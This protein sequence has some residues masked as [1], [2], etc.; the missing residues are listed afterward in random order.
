MPRRLSAAAAPS[1]WPLT[2]FGLA[3]TLVL[4]AFGGVS[5]SSPQDDSGSEVSWAGL[6]GAPRP[7]VVVGQR[8][9]VVLRT[10]ALSDHVRAAGGRATDADQRRWVAQARAAQQLVLSRL[11]VQGLAIQPDHTFERVLNGFAA[12][13]DPRAVAILERSEEVKGI[14]PV[15]SAYPA[16]V[17]SKLLTERD[18]QPGSGHRLDVTLPGFDGRG[19][20]VAL[21]DTGVDRAQ[22]YLR[23]RI[24]DGVDIVGGSDLALAAPHPENPADLERHGTELAGIIVG[25]SGPAD[26]TGVATGAWVLPIRVAGWQRDAAGGY[27]IYARTDQLLAGLERAVDPNGDGVAHDAARI[28]VIGVAEPYNAFADGPLAQAV[29]GALRL[30]TLVVAPAGNDGIGAAQS[31]VR[32]FG[33]VAGPGGAPAALTVGALDIRRRARDVRVTIRAGLQLAYEGRVP[34]GGAVR[35]RT[36]LRLPLAAPLDRRPRGR[37]NAASILSFF[38]REGF[39]LVAGKAA[40]IP[41][42]ASPQDAVENA[43]RAGAGAVIVYGTGPVPSG[44]LGLDEDVGIPV[45]GVPRSAAL[46]AIE[47]IRRGADVAVAIGSLRAR[48]NPNLRRVAPFSSA[49]LAFDGRVKPDLAA[50]G[51]AI[52]TSEP[53]SND[54][55][56]SRF[57][58]VNGSSAAAAVTGGAAALL[59]HARPNLDAAALRSLLANS[60]HPLAAGSIAAQGSGML[61]VGAAAAGELAADPISLALGRAD[62]VAW[63]SATH[64][65]IRNVSTRR[66]RVSL[67]IETL[68]EG[69]AN[70]SFS[71]KPDRFLIRSGRTRRIQVQA[72]VTEEPRGRRP[73]QGVLR[74]NV[75]GGGT[76]RIPWVITFGGPTTNVLGAVQ[77]ST[78]SFKPSDTQPALLTLRAGKVIRTDAGDEIRPVRRLDVELVRANGERLGYLARLRNLIPGHVTIGITGRDPEGELLERGAYRLRIMAWPTERRAP[79]SRAVVRFRIR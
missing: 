32:E 78:R 50:P 55:G 30:D 67:D 24:R 36:T 48:A 31:V 58:T 16:S 63:Q 25:A 2:L 13:L 56:T 65:R 42:G 7:R 1:L 72:L 35:P 23:G 34:L 17:S 10:P 9:I 75:V 5:S 60:A 73:V 41:I 33:S 37:R 54:D 68:A 57:G 45:V 46:R 62:D 64:V 43:A 22:P 47:A 28:A 69:A 20:T 77:L 66:V 21:L 71:L 76:I 11:G 40:L 8:M 53:G 29:A 12:A 26:L 6:A 19:V 61:D 3:V 74:A 15:R 79:A 52:A 18:F 70:I 49:G 44:S 4:V 38:D 14:Y 51:V 59:A 39:S 27:A